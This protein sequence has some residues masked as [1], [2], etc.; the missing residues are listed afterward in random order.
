MRDDDNNRDTIYRRQLTW[1]Y[2][3][4]SVCRV[5]WYVFMCC[6]VAEQIIDSAAERLY[7]YEAALEEYGHCFN[8]M[9]VDTSRWRTRPDS[10]ECF[11]TVLLLTTRFTDY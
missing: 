3:N 5:T 11:G 1:G 8:N 9:S 7:L 4:S 2:V 10:V 6:E